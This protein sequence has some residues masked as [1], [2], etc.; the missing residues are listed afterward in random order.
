[1]TSLKVFKPEEEELLQGYVDT[2]KRDVDDPQAKI[3]FQAN[4]IVPA[5]AVSQTAAHPY[6]LSPDATTGT[7][8]FLQGRAMISRDGGKQ[9]EVNP[10][11]PNDLVSAGTMNMWGSD[12]GFAALLGGVIEALRPEVVLE[13]GTNFGRTAR[14]IAAALA[15]NKM[16]HLTT[17]DMV[18]FEIHTSGALRENE[19]D[20]VTQVI[21]KLPDAYAQEPLAS[22][23]G[24]DVAFLDAGHTAE[25]IARDIEFVEAHRADRCTVLVD[26]A[27]DSQWPGVREFFESYTD[28]P[29]FCFESMCGCQFIQMT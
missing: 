26:N 5:S 27:T 16:G 1:M 28:Y 12:E 17:V 7:E 20:L 3:H 25:E 18:N 24:I 8:V 11:F 29:H 4:F 13:V 9:Y 2:C 14:A 15:K 19:K 23:Q 10:V 6:V 22:M 21:G